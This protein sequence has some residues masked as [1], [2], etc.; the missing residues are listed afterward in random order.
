M[1][2]S[3]IWKKKFEVI[4]MSEQKCVHLISWNLVLIETLAPSPS[5]NL[6]LFEESN[7]EHIG[8]KLLSEPPLNL[9]K[10]DDT[11]EFQNT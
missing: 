1:C 4:V 3:S 8:L 9:V 10:V 2:V 11:E 5:Q 6:K 7:P